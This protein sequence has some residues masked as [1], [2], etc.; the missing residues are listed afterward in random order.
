MKPRPW[1]HDEDSALQKYVIMYGKKW[2]KIAKHFNDRTKSMLRNR[3][4]R[5]TRTASAAATEEDKFQ[6][7][8]DE[9]CYHYYN[10]YTYQFLLCE[11]P[12]IPKTI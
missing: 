8:L 5:I 7:F 6:A 10:C 1:T 3:W 9:Q 11:E 2:N 12:P 4:T